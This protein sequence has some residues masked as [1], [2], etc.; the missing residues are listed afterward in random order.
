MVYRIE[1]EQWFPERLQEVFLFF[2]DAGNLETL[3]PPWLRFRILTP[4]PIQ[5]HQ[6]S[7][8]DYRLSLHG[9]PVRWRTKILV[10]DPPWGFVDK[11]VKGPYRHWVHEHFFAEQ[12]EGTLVRDHITYDMWLGPLVHRLFVRKDLEAIFRLPSEGFH[13][14][15]LRCRPV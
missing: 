13:I 15:L 6:G 7:I 4:Q 10:W 5:F 2:A 1:F 9:F 14:I 8:I 3:T 11:Q 12:E